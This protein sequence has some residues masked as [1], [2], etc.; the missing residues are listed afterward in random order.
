VIGPAVGDVETGD[1]YDAE[2][3]LDGALLV[4]VLGPAR[5]A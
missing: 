3:R 1:P 2:R 5:P 4:H